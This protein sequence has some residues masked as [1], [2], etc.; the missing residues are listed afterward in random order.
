[1]IANLARRLRCDSIVMGTR[2][3][4]ALGNLVLGSLA[5]RVVHLAGVPVTLVK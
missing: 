4:T 3:M 1:V 5:T 2:G